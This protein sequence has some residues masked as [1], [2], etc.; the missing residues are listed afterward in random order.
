MVLQL[1]T[2]FMPVGSLWDMLHDP[3][4][5]DLTWPVR[6]KVLLQTAL[7]MLFLHTRREAVLHRDLKSPNLLLDETMR[8][9]VR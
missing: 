3:A 1:I 5:P 9:K 2:E 7:G 4:L 8:C 6:T